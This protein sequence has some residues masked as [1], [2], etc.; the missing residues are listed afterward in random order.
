MDF[1]KYRPILEAL[2]IAVPLYIV[3]KI[4]FNVSNLAKTA[5]T[6]EYS[7]EQLFGFFS[8]A[9]VLILFI[10]VKIREKNLDNVGYSFL[11]LT[12]LKMAV[13]YFLLRPILQNGNHSQESEKINF[14]IIFMLFLAI[15]TIITIRLLNNKQ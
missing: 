14:F 10:L 6:F 12:S 8:V 4:I 3:H 5:E 1:K 7:L 9:S 11:L 2:I 13:S 15:E